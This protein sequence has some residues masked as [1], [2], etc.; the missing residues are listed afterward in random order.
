MEE[1]KS[2]FS[3]S[4]KAPESGGQNNRNWDDQKI[5]PLKV[6]SGLELSCPK[7]EDIEIT[8]PIFCDIE[9]RDAY[10]NNSNSINSP[11]SNNPSI[12][13]RDGRIQLRVLAMGLMEQLTEKAPRKNQA[14]AL[15]AREYLRYALENHGEGEPFL[16][17]V[18]EFVRH[19][20]DGL[21]GKNIRNLRAYCRTALYNWLAEQPLREDINKKRPPSQAPAS[22][23]LGE[24][25][26]LLEKGGV[27]PP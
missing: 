3:P 27:Y 19:I 16:R 24:L 26:R 7:N 4:G 14:A 20:G 10:L 22:Y 6:K 18:E 8:Y 15:A 2:N 12:G 5:I 17:L 1:Y 23:D 21:Q 11:S 9:N 25:E 13:I